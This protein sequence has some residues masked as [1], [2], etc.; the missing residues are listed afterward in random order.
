MNKLESVVISCEWCGDTIPPE[1]IKKKGMR[2]PPKYCCR[3]HAN[4]ARSRAFFQALSKAGN[5][6]QAVIKQ[7]TGRKPGY[8]KRSKAIAQSNR[9]KPR[10]RKQNA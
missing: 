6:A 3:S 1:K 8:E 7:K 9:E 2:N 10:R 5:A 4:K